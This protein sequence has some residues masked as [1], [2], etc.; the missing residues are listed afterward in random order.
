MKKKMLWIHGWGMHPSIWQ[1]DAIDQRGIPGTSEW[2]HHFFSYA[3]CD[4]IG[5]MKDRLNSVVNELSKMQP[6]AIVGWSMGA[7][8]AAEMV[9][10]RVT[11]GSYLIADSNGSLTSTHFPV[12]RLALIGAPSCF[13]SRD[14]SLGWPKRVVERMKK[15]LCENSNEVLRMFADSMFSKTEKELGWSER[16]R[17]LVSTKRPLGTKE[18]SSTMPP[19]DWT[20]FSLA[21][22][23]AGLT[24][25]IETD[26]RE[27]LEYVRTPLALFHGAEDAI[28]PIGQIEPFQ[29]RSNLWDTIVFE[30]TGHLPFLTQ[31][32]R[33]IKKLGDFVNEHH[34]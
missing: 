7:L 17:K 30:H 23:D 4:S 32:Y 24:Y 33:F 22:L 27:R 2:E 13:C 26:L 9:I 19:L 18:L 14:S 28:C 10:E 5:A 29:A 8:L 11:N 12:D 6:I 3:G 15:G 34:R 31:K 25:L 1:M 16:W 21:G 20:D